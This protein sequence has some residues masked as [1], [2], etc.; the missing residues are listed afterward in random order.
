MDFK[1][2]AEAKDGKIFIILHA[3]ARK[4][5]TTNAI[6]GERLIGYRKEEDRE[7]RMRKEK[8]DD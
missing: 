1:K 2:N 4:T 6:C 8:G 3:V 5:L 7:L